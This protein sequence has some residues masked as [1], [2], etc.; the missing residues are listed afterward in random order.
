MATHTRKQTTAARRAATSV[1]I[2]RT[3]E[4]GRV[5]VRDDGSG[6]EALEVAVLQQLAAYLASALRPGVPAMAD[7]Y[8]AHLGDAHVRVQL[9]AAALEG[10]GPGAEMD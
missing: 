10:G 2:V 5:L 1:P 8:E 4:V 3:L 7:S 9:G 6:T